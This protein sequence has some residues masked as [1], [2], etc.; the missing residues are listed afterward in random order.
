MRKLSFAIVGLALTAFVSG[1]AWAGHTGGLPADKVVVAAASDILLDSDTSD[2]NNA[3]DPVTLFGPISYKMSSSGDL[4]V[5][6]HMECK[7]VTTTKVKGKT[8]GGA[9][10]LVDSE[11]GF[12]RVFVEVSSHDTSSNV[13]VLN[14]S[15]F[16]ASGTDPLCEGITLTD[17]AC[18]AINAGAV[19]MCD[20][21][22]VLTLTNPDEL[23]FDLE[24]KLATLQTHGF[25]W[26]GKNLAK[27]DGS[28]SFPLG[29]QVE[30]TVKG[31]V[32]GDD[33]GLINIRKRV[34]EIDTVHFVE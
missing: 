13:I 16:V 34:L 2:G 22:Q 15:D 27:T 17:T 26:F 33:G 21:A 29:N 4:I 28:D 20:R 7:I 6:V 31:F 19:T 11:R 10:K 24:L 8:N 18:L 30:I 23:N 1:Q 14:A 32:F 3:A 9:Q 25:T 5:T 12:A